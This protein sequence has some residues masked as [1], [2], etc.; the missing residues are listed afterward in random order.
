MSMSL[1]IL[2]VNPPI[3]DF[4]AYDFWL[5][6][7]GV[8]SI[9]GKLRGK[10]EVL[11][12]DYL[13]RCH[14]AVSGDRGC[15]SDEWGRGR[16][17]SEKISKPEVFGGI[18][19]HYRRFGVGREVFGEFISEN[20]PFDFVL[21]QTVMTYWYPGVEEVIDDVRRCQPGAKIIL[22]G[23]YATLCSE[24]AGRLGAELVVKGDELGPLWEL[25]G[26]GYDDEQLPLWEAYRKLEVG[27][28]KLS[29]GCPFKCSYCSVPQV[30]SDFAGRGVEK[31]LGEF[32]LLC[33]LGV[34]DIA[35]YDDAL[36][37]GA[38]KVLVPFLEGVLRSGY[39]VN[40]HT[41][42]A[43]HVRF[44]TKEL[45]DL[46]VRAGFKTF[47]LGYESKSAGW[48]ESTGSKVFS[49]ELSRAVEILVAAGVERR[50]MSVYQILGHPDSEGQ[51][52]EESMRFANGLGVRVMLS[53]F[54]PIPGTVDGEACRKW[55]NLDE[56]LCHN[57]TS[58]PILL[59]GAS[60]VNRLK[61]LC[62]ALNGQLTL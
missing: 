29:D 37:F 2:L 50:N 20:G 22:G 42:N 34:R 25:L 13:D 32:E 44:V 6:P 56:P 55:V 51:E 38:E 28:L 11:L 40:F 62:R 9:G 14:P 61:D 49:D 16:F 46:M 54:S 24:H 30:S 43:L 17:C 15:N 52:V 48:Q 7:Y 19:R 59:L 31:C 57:K 39:R 21:V 45:A 35:F 60:E 18:R 53:D 36:L 33:G 41:P 47:Y 58:F 12:F 8:L 27:V 26:V 10:A 5:K 4:S 1:K 3:Y 23:V